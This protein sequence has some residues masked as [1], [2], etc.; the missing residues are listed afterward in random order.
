MKESSLKKLHTLFQLEHILEKAQIR[1]SEKI[2]GC[3]NFRGKGLGG[4]Q[5]AQGL[6][7]Q[8]DSSGCLTQNIIYFSKP[9]RMYNTQNEC[10]CKVWINIGSVTE[11]VDNRGSCAGRAYM[12]TFSIICSTL[13]SSKA[14]L[15]TGELVKK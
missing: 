8:L 12:R 7:E 11:D 5:V 3:Q 15:N 13:C 6:E 4:L 2:S 14:L 10:Y 1:D 9:V